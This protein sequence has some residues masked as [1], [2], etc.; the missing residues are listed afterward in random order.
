MLVGKNC[1]VGKNWW[2]KELKEVS[3]ELASAGG[4]WFR[5]FFLATRWQEGISFV[6]CQT[7]G[8]KL[9]RVAAE[10]KYVV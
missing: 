6:Y 1:L 9:G 8:Q 3:F 2:G 7:W 4:V 5:G 10:Q